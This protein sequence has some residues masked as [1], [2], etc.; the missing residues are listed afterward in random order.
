MHL[1]VDVVIG[2]RHQDSRLLHPGGDDRLQVIE[3]GPHPGGDLGTGPL[4][5]R[6]DCLAIKRRVGE[7]LGLPDDRPA[8]FGEQVIEMNDLVDG[9]RGPRLLAIA[10]RRVRDPDVGGP[11]LGDAGWLEADRRDSGVGKIVA[12]QV[13]L[14]RI[15]HGPFYAYIDLHCNTLTATPET[16]RLGTA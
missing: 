12:Q 1:Q 10:E 3:R 15:D 2:G 6:G 7:K 5:A 8:Q 11:R 4:L 16:R 14:G 9:V 13:G